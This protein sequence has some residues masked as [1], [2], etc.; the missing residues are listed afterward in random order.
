LA[1]LDWL[2]KLPFGLLLWLF[3]ESDIVLCVV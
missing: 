3:V 2:L 1:F